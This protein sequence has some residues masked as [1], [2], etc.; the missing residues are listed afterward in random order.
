MYGT[1]CFARYAL[2][3]MDD[4][5][6]CLARFVLHFKGSTVCMFGTLCFARYVLHMMGDTLCFGH[7][8]CLPHYVSHGMS[9]KLCFVISP[10]VLIES[11]AKYVEI[12]LRHDK[13]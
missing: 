12:S 3:I 8:A 7:Y 13:V 2:H 4:I 9:C 5:Y 1:L 11:H 6:A 10:R